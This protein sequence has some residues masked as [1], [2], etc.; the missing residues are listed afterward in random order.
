MYICVCVCVCVCV[1]L[2]LVCRRR[3]DVHYLLFSFWGCLCNRNDYEKVAWCAWYGSRVAI[4]QSLFGFFCCAEAQAITCASVYV[5]LCVSVCPCVTNDNAK[6]CH[7]L[8]TTT[9]GSAAAFICTPFFVSV[10]ARESSYRKFWI[11]NCIQRK[12]NQKNCKNEGT[13]SR[14]EFRKHNNDQEAHQHII[15]RRD[16]FTN[17]YFLF[18]HCL[19]FPDPLLAAAP[20]RSAITAPR[21][22]QFR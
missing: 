22:D 4:F 16:I 6:C 5:C 3:R 15:R 7:N 20:H 13:S 10:F 8:T 11:F 21:S 12:K 2:G 19:S 9:R 1:C 17:I 14:K 18:R